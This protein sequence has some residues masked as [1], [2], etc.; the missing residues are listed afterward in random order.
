[1]STY[2]H[3]Q[4]TFFI[5]RSTYLNSKVVRFM[6]SPCFSL[7]EI[8]DGNRIIFEWTLTRYTRVPQEDNV[9]SD[10]FLYK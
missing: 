1:M 4:G 7:S 9:P 6:E 10:T 3:T 5:I 2:V 8:L